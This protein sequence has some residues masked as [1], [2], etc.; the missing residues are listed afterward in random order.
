MKTFIRTTA[1]VLI[2]MFAQHTFA[3]ATQRVKVDFQNG[4]IV[5]SNTG[6]LDGE[7]SKTTEAGSDFIVGV[8]NTSTEV[9][10]VPAILS[11]GI[12]YVKFD[13]SNGE[14]VK[15]D[16]IT[17]SKVSGKG[18]KANAS[19]MMVGV[20]LESST[21]D[22]ELLKILVQPAWVKLPNKN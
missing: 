5:A 14:V 18:M 1:L 19:G 12:A 8:Y 7:F 2:T 4:D 13:H 17:S 20:A 10:N 3:Q 15:G 22:T 21:S 6:R 16:L 11:S 9:K